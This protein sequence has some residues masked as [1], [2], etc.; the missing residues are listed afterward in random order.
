MDSTPPSAPDVTAIAAAEHQE[1]SR[2][3]SHLV[4]ARPALGITALRLPTAG[5]PLVAE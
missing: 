5:E 4:A 1:A 2:W 3:V